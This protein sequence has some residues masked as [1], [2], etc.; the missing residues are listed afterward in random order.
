MN[1]AVFYFDWEIECIVWLQ[2]HLGSFGTY[3]SEFFTL[4][5]E[6][7]TLV[8]LFGFLYWCLDKEKAKTIGTNLLIA[9]IINPV[10]KNIILRRRPYFDNAQIKCLKPVNKKADIYD[11]SAQ[12]YSF[13][14]AH[15]IDSTIMYGGLACI[16][17]NRIFRII[18]ILLT[19]AVGISRFS[20]GVH[21]PTDVLVGWIL[22]I[23]IIIFVPYLQNKV[24]N[25][26]YFRLVILLISLPGIPF[27]HTDDY[28]TGLGM[29]IGFF[30]AI[31]FEERF[32][33]FKETRHPIACI[34]RTVG[35]FG[36]MT[37]MNYLIKL[38]FPKTFLEN[39]SLAAHLVR[40]GRYAIILF[41]LFAIYPILF[42][43][44]HLKHTAI[45]KG[46]NLD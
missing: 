22:G 37:A 10:L 39:G 7:T 5:G 38:P 19:L 16:Y 20:L 33:G 35:G 6:E 45:R 17:K 34:L 12:G 13:P 9:L 24:K 11:V 4:F 30:F 23:I 8:L 44:I 29:L 32:V 36:L 43:K 21:Y 40:T 25:K 27:C 46:G 42:D 15:A 14:S 2:S 31:L 1:G 26:N 3:L 28:F 18:M 41:V